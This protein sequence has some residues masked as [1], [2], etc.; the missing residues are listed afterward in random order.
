MQRKK[1]RVGRQARLHFPMLGVTYRWEI[2]ADFNNGFR[3]RRRFISL[4]F[5]Q[6]CNRIL[7][8][9]MENF[10]STGNRCL[11]LLLSS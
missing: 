9:Y 5:F 10:A 1:V 2:D 4:R 8:A 6:Q 7:E 11:R 3:V